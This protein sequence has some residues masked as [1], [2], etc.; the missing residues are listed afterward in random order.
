VATTTLRFSPSAPRLSSMNSRLPAALADQADDG[1]VRL[2]MP[3]Q[4]RQQAGLANAGAGENA[5]TLSPAARQERVQRP[6]AEIELAL[7]ALARV[8]RRRRV[9]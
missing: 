6:D 3:R 4:H 1:D 2:G 7:H 9:A 8:R 5:E